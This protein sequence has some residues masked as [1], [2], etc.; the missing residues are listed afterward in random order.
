MDPAETPVSLTIVYVTCRREPRVEWFL[1]SLQRQI[2]LGSH[3]PAR[4]RVVVVD[5]FADTRPPELVRRADVWTTPKPSV[6]QGPHRLVSRDWFAPSNARNTGV[7]FA[8]GSH[9]AF[10]DDLSV[11]M[12]GWL[13]VVTYEMRHNP[14]RV[15][16]GRYTKVRDLRVEKGEVVSF[17]G[18]PDGTDSRYDADAPVVR[19]RKEWLYGASM[20]M[21]LAAI[22]DINGFDED[23]DSMGG[24]DYS[25]GIVLENHGWPV[26]YHQ[27]MCTLEDGPLHRA[28][29]SFIRMTKQ[30]SPRSTFT[31]ENASRAYLDRIQG[32]PSY[33]A[34]PRFSLRTLRE[35][36][37]DGAPFPVP[38]FPRTDW[39]DGQPLEEM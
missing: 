8:Q 2:A 25:A 30:R 28:G 34:N 29:P 11:L 39:R 24:E 17:F 33:K 31:Q 12:P 35:D 21:P 13:N 4:F 37:L 3:D 27:G 23:C 36:T 6:W 14:G 5:F 20:C 26:Y 38:D 16:A 7:A 15:L 19:R 9:V 1:D 10:V 32:D 22:L 18:Y